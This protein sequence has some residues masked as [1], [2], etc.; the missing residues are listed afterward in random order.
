MILFIAISANICL[1]EDEIPVNIKADNLKYSEDGVNVSAS[2]SVEIEIKGIKILSDRLLMNTRSNIVTAEGNVK[3]KGRD[4][5]SSSTLMT[6]YVSDETSSFNSFR[7]VLAPSTVHGRLYLGADKIRD[8]KT[9]WTGGNGSMTTCDYAENNEPHY[10]VMSKKIEYYPNDKIVGWS[11]TFYIGSIPVFWV[12]YII[13]DLNQKRKK[14]WTIGH[15]EVE[16]NFIKTFWDYP[17]GE[18]LLDEMEKKGFGHGIDYNYNLGAKGKGSL[19]L[20][21]LNENDSPNYKDQVFKIS[22]T[23][24]LTREG[25]LSLGYGSSDIYLIPSGRLGQST[26]SIGYDYSKDKRKFTTSLN[27]LENRIGN[28]ERVDLS[29]NNISDNINT[30]Y[31]FSLD[32][33]KTEPRF[34]RA[35][36]RLNHSQPFFFKDSN[37]NFNA[38]Y[39]NN[40]RQA[41]V[42]GDELLDLDYNITGRQDLYSWKISENRH[43]RMN[44]DP[45]Y[46]N[47]DQFQEKAP[48]VT[49]AFNPQDLKLFTLSPSLGYGYYREVTQVPNYGRRDF[50]TGKY[51][52]SL[53][54]NRSIPLILGTSLY[55]SYGIDQYLYA[56]G[57]ALYAQNEKYSLDTSLLNFF[58][59]NVTFDRGIS[60]GNSPFLFDRLGTKYS[61]LKDTVTMYYGNYIRWVTTGGFNYQTDQYFNIDTNL[62]LNPNPALNASFITGWDIENQKWEDLSVNLALKP[63]NKLSDSISL[64]TDLNSG[65]LK[66]GSNLFDFE[67]MDEDHWQNHWHLKL[68]HVYDTTTQQ[69][70]SVDVMVEKDLHCWVINYTYSDYRKEFSFTFTLKA[71][72]GEPIGYA[73]GKGFYFDTFDQSLKEE[74]EGA[75]PVRY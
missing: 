46:G 39:S 66:S 42:A 8:E 57:D 15:N 53:A 11:N 9:S 21:L 35:S 43:V 38:N 67:I 1:G 75:S 23:L 13:Y 60:E 37:L 20:Y 34:I 2:G 7:T 28:E 74:F 55:L 14:N 17:N 50:A 24:Q 70:K 5:D 49:L 68:G 58:Q 33:G 31:G 16:G 54:A 41:G 32:Q 22:H 69:F 45:L 63:F 3:M 44:S 71:F 18:I 72:P 25:T 56:P 62:K 73:A 19:Y 59:N 52:A 29:V 10:H 6:Y 36:Q 40:I 30:G 27:A 51:T 4:Y 47:N 64:L 26:Y 61:N 12:P 48:E 65:Q